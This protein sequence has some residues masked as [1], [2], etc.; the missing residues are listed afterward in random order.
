MALARAT[1]V[2]VVGVA[3]HL[4][5]VQADIAA[6][7]PG[8][9]LIGLPDAALHEARDRIR[10]AVVNSRETWPSQ[11]ITVG[12]FP[13]T[14][15]KSGSGFDLAIAAAVIAAD[16]KIPA[17]ALTGRVL[18]G[19]LSLDG[20][21]RPLR[22]VLPA[23][24]AASR[25]G[26]ER[27]VVP[28]ENA[29]E[30]ALVPGM[31]IEPV[32]DLICLLELLR[33]QLTGGDLPAVPQ[34]LPAQP[35]AGPD[36]VD[37]AGQARGRL[38]IEVVGRG[39]PPLVVAG[40]PGRGPPR[41]AERGQGGLAGRRRSGGVGLAGHV[42]L[43]RELGDPARGPGV[44]VGGRRRPHE[45]QGRRLAEGRVGVEHHP[46]VGRPRVDVGARLVVALGDAEGEHQLVG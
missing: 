22:G 1:G 9:T 26:V 3:G 36:L 16:G 29:A 32:T 17:D 33:G 40:P 37:V 34:R 24:L 23:V 27:V 10:A 45:G 13:A 11:R 46:Q 38:A 25:A 6:G 43:R 14:L 28:V 42:G 18:L 12:L 41:L 15:R 44:A 2:A 35:S 20:R 7:L 39:G 5:D 19:E 30:A 4:V 8:L 21:L 31:A